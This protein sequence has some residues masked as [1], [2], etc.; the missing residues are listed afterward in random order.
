MGFLSALSIKNNEQSKPLAELYPVTTADWQRHFGCRARVAQQ[1]FRDRIDAG[2]S[3]F[4]ALSP[5]KLRCTAERLQKEID[6]R[7]SK[8]NATSS[9]I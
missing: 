5:R 8:K 7:L 4:I 6:S 2:D 9:H 1:F 3:D